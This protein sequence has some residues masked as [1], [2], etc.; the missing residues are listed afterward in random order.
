MEVGCQMHCHSLVEGP[1]G[2]NQKAF[3]SERNNS[4]SGCLLLGAVLAVRELG[5]LASQRYRLFPMLWASLLQTC[6]CEFHWHSVHF[7]T[8]LICEVSQ[9]ASEGVV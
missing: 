4:V 5:P 8:P 1:E 7:Q 6:Y 2:R 9:S 3:C